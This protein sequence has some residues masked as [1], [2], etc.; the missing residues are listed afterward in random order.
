MSAEH[1]VVDLMAALEASLTRAKSQAPSEGMPPA[2]DED[3]PWL[4]GVSLV[5]TTPRV[6]LKCLPADEW[7]AMQG[8]K[9]AAKALVEDWRNG[10]PL[11]IDGLAQVLDGE[12]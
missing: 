12:P 8:I 2:D 6:R 5:S 11:D 3:P 9:A 4:V 1:K 7:D 10:Q